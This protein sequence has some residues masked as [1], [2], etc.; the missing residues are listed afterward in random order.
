MGSKEGRD[1]IRMVLIC[2][3]PWNFCCRNCGMD[4]VEIMIRI[5]GEGY[6]NDVAEHH[7]MPLDVVEDNIH[8][9]LRKVMLLMLSKKVHG[10]GVAEDHDVDVADYYVV[11]VLRKNIVWMLSKI[12]A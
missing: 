10:V 3:R 5:L 9:M 11:W 6:A 12:V 4:V 1:I 7:G 2:K 8:W